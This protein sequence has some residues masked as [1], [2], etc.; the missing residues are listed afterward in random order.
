MKANE[1]EVIPLPEKNIIPLEEVPYL[2]EEQLFSY[3]NRVVPMSMVGTIWKQK[4]GR[5]Y[6]RSTPLHAR[7]NGRII[8]MGKNK[9]RL[10]FW[11]H[12]IEAVAPSSHQEKRGRKPQAR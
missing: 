6:D 1:P 5:D 11:T 12:E 8:P 4:T 3:G 9:N 2:T 10:Y 7:L